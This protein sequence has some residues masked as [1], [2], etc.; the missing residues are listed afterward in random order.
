VIEGRIRV[1]SLCETDIG[2]ST[3]CEVNSGELIGR[4]GDHIY[5]GRI[6]REMR[7]GRRWRWKIGP[8]MSKQESW[9]CP[10][11]LDSGAQKC[12][13]KNNES[14]SSLP[15]SKRAIPKSRCRRCYFCAPFIFAL[16]RGP[17]K[18]ENSE[19]ASPLSSD[20]SRCCTAII[21]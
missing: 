19:Y 10:R 21:P 17:E 13:K 2:I 5:P 6:L 14:S 7:E 4:R 11:S 8:S 9:G 18:L 1:K 16:V 15:A 3:F 12:R 20:V